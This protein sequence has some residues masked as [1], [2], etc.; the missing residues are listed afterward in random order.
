MRHSLFAISLSVLAI[1]A[2]AGTY[3][4]TGAAND[5]LWFTAGNWNY[6]GAP[7][8]SSPGNNVSDDIVIDGAGVVVTYLP[9]GDLI[10]QAGST[11]TVSGGATLAQDGGAWPFFHGTVVIDGGT[12]DYKN[13]ASNPGQVRLDGRMELRNGGAFY[14]NQLVKSGDAA[15][16][17]IGEGVTFSVDGTVN[18]DSAPLYQEMD[19]GTLYIGS[20]FQ[21]RGT[22]TFTGS[23]TINCNIFAPQDGQSA[24][25]FNGPNLIMRTG[26]FDGFWQS[27]STYI[28]VTAGSA[29]KFTIMSGFKNADDIYPKTFGSSTTNP[30]Y[31][32]N[33]EIIDRATFDSLF[34]VEDH[35]EAIDGDTNYADFYLTPVSADELVFVGGTITATLTSDTSATLSAT[36]ENAGSPVSGLVALYGLSDAGRTISG[37]DHAVDLGPAAAGVVSAVVA[38]EPGRLYHYRLV[39]T[40]AEHEVWASPNPATL[41]SMVK[42]GAPTNIWT[43][44]VS[45]DSRNPS[46]WSLGHVP[47]ETETVLVF[48]RFY[49]VRLEWNI[50]TGSDTVAGWVQPADFADQ[51]HQV[52]FHTT[53]ASPVTVTGDVVLNGGTW[54]H[55][56][57][58]ETPS[59][60]VNVVV[61][62]AMTIGANARIAVGTAQNGNDDD[63][64]SRGYVRGAGPG[65]LRTAGGSY[66]GEGGHITNTTGFVTYGSV[67][68][69]LSHGSGGW[70]DMY[71]YAGGGV[72]KLSVGG[73]L[74]VDGVVRSRGFG[75]PLNNDYAG[76]SGSGGSVNLTAASIAGSGSV[77]AN[78]G[79]N[80]LYGPGSGG[81]VRIALTGARSSFEGFAG[82]VEAVGGSM[83]TAAGAAAYDVSPA[84]AGTV[85]LTTADGVSVVKVFNE[86]R[87]GDTA[88][89]WRVASGEAIP[90]ATHL[91]AMQ[92]GDTAA[93][94]K[95]TRWELSGNGAIRLTA[96]AR[97][98]SLTLAS[99][100]GSQRV[101]TEGHTLTVDSFRV[102]NSAKR[103][104]QTAADL[105]GV[106][107]GA[108]AVVVN[109]PGT[110]VILH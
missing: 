65:Y 86:F 19:G 50:G 38:L 31:R 73:A 25:S 95:P 66:A 107:F 60:M 105:P 81:R 90:S 99:G 75:Y 43:G 76:G 88:T 78:G 89:A 30:K 62:G 20:E 22:A 24:V 3:T 104:V 85:C 29:S 74:T 100:D 70:G 12:L 17:V 32:Y 46:N 91:P 8:A 18:G 52:V 59:E 15:R 44:A 6:D 11:L 77:D 37:W 97:V 108:G 82:T 72:V 2:S 39:A 27:G 10:T 1:A 93:A 36:V 53:A 106:V 34:T 101:Y 80:G 51:K 102:G 58:S 103:G 45:T 63:G 16:F 7:A 9:G 5:G 79:A 94:L 35:G 69:P 47:A 110:V 23:G 92:D 48:D 98:A 26:S 13:N 42:P 55:G 96:D 64:L 33:G 87:F 4:W 21:P 109:D 68:N 84:A 41:Y 40:N 28:N 67:L 14:A 49:P 57:P 56:G 54:T 83:Q 71:F 61:G